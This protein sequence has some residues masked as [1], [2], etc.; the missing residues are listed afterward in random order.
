MYAR[1]W[2]GILSDSLAEVFSKPIDANSQNLKR[3]NP[4]RLT[5]TLNASFVCNEKIKKKKGKRWIEEECGNEWTSNMTTV[6]FEY[7]AT[8]MGGLIKIDKFSQSCKVCDGNFMSP[9]YDRESAMNAGRKLKEKILEKFYGVEKESN[10]S[11]TFT[12]KGQKPHESK[13]CEACKKGVCPGR[14]SKDWF[15]SNPQHSQTPNPVMLEINGIST[16]VRWDLKVKGKILHLGGTNKRVNKAQ[17]AQKLKDKKAQDAQKLKDKKAQDAQKLKDKKAKAKRESALINIDK[18]LKTETTLASKYIRK[19]GERDGVITFYCTLCKCGTGLFMGKENLEHHLQINCKSCDIAFHG[20]EHFQNHM[21]VNHEKLTDEQAANLLSKWASGLMSEIE[22]QEVDT[23]KACKVTKEDM[24]NRKKGSKHK[25]ES[26]TDVEPAAVGEKL[27]NYCD[28]CEISFSSKKTME[29]HILGSKHRKSMER[30]QKDASIKLEP[31]KVESKINVEPTKVEEKIT[32]HCDICEINCNSSK[33]ME[34]HIQG[35][36][37]KKSQEKVLK[38]EP[39]KV[40][41]KM[42]FDCNISQINSSQDVENYSAEFDQNDRLNRASKEVVE[43]RRTAMKE[44]KEYREKRVAE[45]AATQKLRN[46]LRGIVSDQ[47]EP[48]DREEEVLGL[49]SEME[50]QEVVQGVEIKASRATKEDMESQNKGSKHL[51]DSSTDVEPAKVKPIYCD[52]CESNCYSSKDMESHIKG[53]KHKKRSEK[54]LKDASTKLQPTKVDGEVTCFCNICEINCK[55][56]QDMNSHIQGSQHKTSLER[57]QKDASI[58]VGPTK[59]EGKLTIQCDICKVNCTSFKDMN[60]HIKGSKHKKMQKNLRKMTLDC[61]ICEIKSNSSKDME[62]HIQG[63]D[64]RK[65]VKRLKE[66][67][68]VNVKP[69]KVERELTQ[70]CKLLKYTKV[71]PTEEGVSGDFYCNLCGRNYSNKSNYETHIIGKKHKKKLEMWFSK[72]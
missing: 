43:K 52:I 40:E 44:Y 55:S 14:E 65:S 31:T 71:E 10:V 54:L 19:K 12:P 70:N 41:G 35:S 29:S 68:L 56:S 30:L 57:L 4:L 63:A 64:H 11:G 1:F 46:E 24:E 48:D 69:T 2:Q 47:Q 45:Y 36:K 50:A 61:N 51:K 23:T 26:S 7:E 9:M 8:R 21:I 6:L 38:L 67:A 60:S 42:T 59:G 72:N 22:T 66:D 15:K 13:Y 34:S 20:F 53:L 62:S 37:H 39:D 28:I 17:D 27:P 32:I 25:K 5:Y 49:K 58:E 3:E 18:Q 33:D 16:Y